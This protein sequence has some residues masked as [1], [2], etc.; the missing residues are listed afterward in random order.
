MRDRGRRR[1]GRCGSG[2]AHAAPPGP[3]ALPAPRGRPAVCARAEAARGGGTPRQRWRRRRRRERGAAGRGARGARRSAGAGLTARSSCRPDVGGAGMEESEVPSSSDAAPQAAREEPSESGVGTSE[4]VSVTADSSD[5]AAGAALPSRADDSGVGQSSD[6]S[7][8]CLVRERAAGA[9]LRALRCRRPGSGGPSGR[10][11]GAAPRVGGSLSGGRR[12]RPGPAAEQSAA[13]VCGG[14][15]S[16]RP[17]GRLRAEP[18]C[19]R[20]FRLGRGV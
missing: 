18:F 14:S 12:S 15:P 20:C 9:A 2:P 4:A 19:P 5:A 1:E 6:R 7:A 11:G 10:G 3:A 17:G 13:L 8:A 16:A